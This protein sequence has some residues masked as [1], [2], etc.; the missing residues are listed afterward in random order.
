MTTRRGSILFAGAL[1]PVLAP[2]CVLPKS[3]AGR[4]PQRRG[5]PTEIASENARAGT[6]AWDGPEATAPAIE[7]YASEVS[8]GPGDLL[9]FHVSTSPE[10]RYRIE[11]YRLGWYGGLGGRRVECLPG[12]QSAEQGIAQPIPKDFTKSTRADWPVTDTAEVGRSWVSGYYEARFVLTSGPEAGRASE[13]YFVVRAPPGRRSQILVQV[14]VN[15]WQAYND[16][17]GRSLYGGVYGAGYR[18]SFDRPYTW[19]LLTSPLE[20]EIQ[21]VRFL[22]RNG[23]DV[24]YQTDLDTDRDPDSLLQHNL[25]LTA[26]HDEYWTKRIRDAFESARDQGVN[27]AFMGANVG[28]W[29]M[30]YEDGGQTIVEYREAALDP[31]PDPALKTVKFRRLNPPRPECELRGVNYHGGWSVHETH[32]YA[33]V[34]S[35]IGDPWFRDTGFTVAS[36]L[37][38]LVGREWDYVEPTCNVPT[39]T[40]LFHWTGTPT[41]ADAA[42]YVARS[43]AIVFSAGSLQFSW[44]LDAFDAF[45][46]HADIPPDLRLQRFMRNALADLVR[47]HG[48]ALPR[49][50]PCD[51][52]ASDQLC[53]PPSGER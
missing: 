33:P 44:G 28:F 23:Y 50:S 31:N 25:V 17:G 45:G 22:E 24:S 20:W 35:S 49:R 19:N 14:P 48:P 2:L 46:T 36:R 6:V 38:G 27:L 51:T 41:N 18:V 30:R 53:L 13:T 42:R 47:R 34:A 16:W 1:L 3:T 39:P 52:A 40:V 37:R 7:G 43:G 12:C 5:R 4:L 11:L 29:Q 15:T 26:G 8:V 10:G 9:H 21:L 32:D